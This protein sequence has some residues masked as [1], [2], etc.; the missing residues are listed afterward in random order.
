MKGFRFTLI[1]LLVSIAI[2]SVLASLLLPALG[3]ARERAK[4]IGC[5]GSLRQL[6]LGFGCYAGDY[7]GFIPPTFY[8]TG[9]SYYFWTAQL[10]VGGGV[11]PKSF[12]C[13]GF[14]GLDPEIAG[15]YMALGK[16]LSSSQALGFNFRY[17]CYGL[18]NGFENVDANENI[19]SLPSL[20]RVLQPS[21]SSL[22]MDCY[23]TESMNCG[24]FRMASHYPL[25]GG[26][27]GAL[28]ARHSGSVNAAMADGHAASFKS[29][30]GGDRLSYGTG[31]NPYSSK[32]FCEESG[33]YW[34]PCAN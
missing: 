3:S 24:R 12:L 25:L 28:D 13:P 22:T 16:D 21:R 23:A 29:S 14:K 6:S 10:V 34:K 18:T 17:P 4:G 8:K 26:A 32:P 11:S 27:W 7:K 33:A 20:E 9:G 31:C 19:L 2:V 5:L 1:E 30:C 15:W